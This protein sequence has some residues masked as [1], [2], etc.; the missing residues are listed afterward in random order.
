MNMTTR[1]KASVKHRQLRGVIFDMDGVLIDSHAAHRKAWR[2]FFQTLGIKIP[3]GELDFILDGHKRCEI[4][5]HFLGELTPTRLEELGRRKDQIFR[6]VQT[7]IAPV[8]GAIAFVRELHAAG[9]VMAVA[10]SASRSR[11]NSTLERLGLQPQ[12]SAVVTGED[13]AVG[14]PDPAVYRLACAQIGLG[15]EYLLAIEDAVSGIRAAQGAGLRCIGIAQHKPPGKLTAA[16]AVQVMRN[17][18]SISVEDLRTVLSGQG[19]G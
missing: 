11:A 10:T 7:G 15:P 4:L 14:K 1:V 17:F 8:P 16:G 18:E 3:A 12:F 6:R 13:V 9:I 2:R 5:K 19:A